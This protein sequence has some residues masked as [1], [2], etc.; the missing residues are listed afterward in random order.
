LVASRRWLIDGPATAPAGA[1]RRVL[2]HAA[3]SIP[4][5]AELQTLHRGN[6][7]YDQRALLLAEHGDLVCVLGT[8][9]PAYVR[10]LEELG[11]GPGVEQVVAVD[12]GPG[13]AG[14][15]AATLTQALLR[16][17]RA[18]ARLAARAGADRTVRLEP[19]M[20]GRDELALAGRLGELL[21][22]EVELLGEPG[23]AD[24]A[25]RKD[26]Q[27]QWAQELGIPV[28][29]GETVP[30]EPAADG[31]P[32]STEP[33]RSA[34]ARRLRAGERVLVRGCQGISGSATR[35]VAGQQELASVLSWAASRREAAY[36]VDRLYPIGPSPNVLVF[37]APEGPV[38]LVG[39]TDQVLDANLHHAGNRFPSSARLVDEMI[40]HAEALGRH[41]RGIGYSG[42]AGCDF[43]EYPDPA[44]GTPRLFFAELNARTNGA[45]YPIVAASRLAA[46]SRDRPMAFVSGYAKTTASSFAE[47]S[48]RLGDR[49]LRP[50]GGT[51]ILPY[52]TGCL[53]HGYCSVLVL[54]ETP[55]AVQRRWDEVAGELA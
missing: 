18:L 2:V 7:R 47:L 37:V 10:Y 34:I 13:G 21:G 40:A 42:W 12:P 22:R 54:D 24:R 30:L 23:A 31:T 36:L 51:G 52:N 9:E 26:L 38:R 49:L 46:A 11:L 4:A 3:T 39:A 25:N 35:I 16:D 6:K 55:E 53:A 45:S 41:L 50:G 20:A 15:A 19:F 29:D 33:L 32:G 27:R 28:A 43:C 14:G 44:T 1:V 17:G 8:A 48:G 5:A